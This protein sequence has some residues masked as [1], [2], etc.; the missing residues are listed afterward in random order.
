MFKTRIVSSS[1]ILRFACALAI[2]LPM[3]SAQA[4]VLFHDDFSSE[5]SAWGNERGNWRVVDGTYDATNPNNSPVT[6]SSVTTLPALKDFSVDVDVRRLDDG[7]VWLRSDFNGG[8]IN[9]ILLITGGDLGRNNGLY[10]HVV[11]N[12]VVSRILNLGTAAGVQET[13]RHLHIEVA[14]GTYSAYLDGKLITTLVNDE[15]DDGFVGL[16][17]FS[18]TSRATDPRGQQFDNFSVSAVP[19]SDVSTPSPLLLLMGAGL[20]WLG[21]GKPRQVAESLGDPE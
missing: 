15:F 20:V 13:D 21:L 1:R 19:I 17:D 9:G 6:Y 7:G 5:S 2:T 11:K 12:G 18:P 8:A 4:T 3:A 14:E 16:Y 10:W